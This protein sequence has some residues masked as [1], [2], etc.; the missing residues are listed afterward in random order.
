MEFCCFICKHE[1]IAICH[2]H[3][4]N[5]YTHLQVD[6]NNLSV[7]PDDDN[8]VDFDNDDTGAGGIQQ[9][10]HVAIILDFYVTYVQQKFANGK[11][12][13]YV[14]DIYLDTRSWVWIIDFNVWGGRTDALLYNW[15]ELMLLGKKVGKIMKGNSNSG[16]T[17]SGDVGLILKVIPEW[18][19]VSK[20]MNSMTYDPL[21]SYR[22]PTDVVNLLGGSVND[23][24]DENF[25]EFM[26]QCVRPSEM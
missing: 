16:V 25:E 2:R 15:E 12:D 19:V 22:G 10:P 5:Y 23:V 3:P 24:S 11:V 8:D 14:L 9:H 20:S 21:S 7:E 6:D 17:N 13:S 1:V 4:S 18:K 26:K